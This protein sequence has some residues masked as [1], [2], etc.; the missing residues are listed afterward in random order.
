M[1]GENRDK[2]TMTL[3]PKELKMFVNIDMTLFSIERWA[4]PYQKGDQK[5][6]LYFFDFFG[7]KHV[8]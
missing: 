3:I 6:T 8:N 1:K 4:N 5:T 7:L 2:R